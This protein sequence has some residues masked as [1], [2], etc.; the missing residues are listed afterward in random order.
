MLS[1]SK[2]AY[3]QNLFYSK[4]A[5]CCN[6][7]LVTLTFFKTEGGDKF[8]NFTGDNKRVPDKVVNL[9]CLYQRDLNDKQREKLGVNQEVTDIL[10]VSPIELEK[11]FGSNK[12]PQEVRNS[13]AMI[14]VEFLGKHYELLSIKDLEP[15]HNGKEVMCIAYQINL[16]A[17]TGN[18]DYN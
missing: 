8:S 17:T 4:L 6:P 9:H 12:F 18:Y 2:F 7:V 13:Y 10:Y 16:R 1:S 14:S 15:M 5:T 11:K 3:L